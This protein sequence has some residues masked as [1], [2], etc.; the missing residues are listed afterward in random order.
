M[1]LNRFKLV[2]HFPTELWA[3][4]HSQVYISNWEVLPK[5]LFESEAFPECK[6][7]LHFFATAVAFF[8]LFYD[9]WQHVTKIAADTRF[10]CALM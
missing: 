9:S 10:D 8:S 3:Q 5:S 6:V 7:V 4:L 2:A 1:F